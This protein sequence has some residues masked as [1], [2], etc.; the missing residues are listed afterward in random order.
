MRRMRPLFW[1]GHGKVATELI[2][3]YTT[4]SYYQIILSDQNL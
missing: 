3:N 4:F 1:T 2:I